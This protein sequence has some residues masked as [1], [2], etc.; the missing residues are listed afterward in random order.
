MYK[1]R[2]KPVKDYSHMGFAQLRKLKNEL[3]AK[4]AIHRLNKV[5]NENIERQINNNNSN[6][7][8]RIRAFLDSSLP[9]GF[10]D[11]NHLKKRLEE[12]KSEMFRR[13]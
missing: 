1:Q 3:D 11:N 5:H 4:E 10:R 12:I 7:Y 13:Y 2:K 9:V 6:E 8:T